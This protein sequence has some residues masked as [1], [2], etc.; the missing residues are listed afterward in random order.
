MACGVPIVASDTAPVKEVIRNGENGRL[1]GFFDRQALERAV[2]QMLNDAEAQLQIRTS[3]RT[4]AETYTQSAGLTRYE[5]LWKG[6]H[7]EN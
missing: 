5:N 7:F 3:A 4:D 6:G 1:V 2:L